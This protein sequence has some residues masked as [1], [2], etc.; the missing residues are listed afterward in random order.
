M[1]KCTPKSEKFMYEIK[2]A[3]EDAFRYSYN[4]YKVEVSYDAD[5]L[6]SKKD[7]V[8][9][10]TLYSN[11]K[12]DSDSTRYLKEIMRDAGATSIIGG[13]KHAI[14]RDYLDLAFDI[15]KEKL[16]ELGIDF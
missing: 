14:T 7:Y 3:I 10:I 16:K 8:V 9:D 6:Y 12:W 11:C 13:L 5:P 4:I 15:K 2:R 1:S